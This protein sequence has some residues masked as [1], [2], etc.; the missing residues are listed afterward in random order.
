MFST[1]RQPQ[2]YPYAGLLNSAEIKNGAFSALTNAG[3]GATSDLV[4]AQNVI[5]KNSVFR[6]ST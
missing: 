2:A 6:Q 5:D 3:F 1:L 4:M